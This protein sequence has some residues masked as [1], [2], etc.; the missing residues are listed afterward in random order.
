MWHLKLICVVVFLVLACG[1]VCHGQQPPMGEDGLSFRADAFFPTGDDFI[2]ATGEP[3]LGV[4]WWGSIAEEAVPHKPTTSVPFII[5]FYS[6]S[7]GLPDISLA[8]YSVDAVETWT[9]G[10]CRGIEGL[11]GQDVCVRPEPLYRYEVCLDGDVMFVPKP[12][13]EYWLV[14]NNTDSSEAHFWSWHET[15]PP[16]PT[17]N[18]AATWGFD[19]FVPGLINA[20]P[21]DFAFTVGPYDLAF[22][23]LLDCPEACPGDLDR[24]GSVGVKDLLILLGVWGPCPPKEDC[25]ADFDDSGDVGVKDLLDLLGNWGPCA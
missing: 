19:D 7:G 8:S 10:F 11:A 12:G 25:P 6:S 22:E 21:G 20:C 9:G 5:S 16:H 2:S 18:E 15:E 23:L 4:R 1:A 24:N 13:V 17:G 14:I 3:I